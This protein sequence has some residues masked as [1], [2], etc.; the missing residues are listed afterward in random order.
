MIPFFQRNDLIR[1]TIT[2]EVYRCISAEGDRYIFIGDESGR[3]QFSK[4]N[5]TPTFFHRFQ[6]ITEEDYAQM[7]MK[8]GGAK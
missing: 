4:D 6:I 8:K 5:L 7:Q 1:S 2:N 3:V